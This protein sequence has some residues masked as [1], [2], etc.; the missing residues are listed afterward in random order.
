MPITADLTIRETAALSGVSLVT[1]EKTVEAQVMSPV[2][3]PSRV[4]G[5][6][7]RYLPLRAVVYFQ[8]LKAA[9]LT[10]LPLRHKR[11]IWARMAQLEPMKLETIEF[12]P[13]A[14]L[15]LERLA[16][17]SLREAERYRRDRDRYIASDPGILGGTPVIA[18][19]RVSV[20]SILGRLQDGD[21]VD[22]ILQDYPEIPREAIVAAEL[23]AKAHPL[24]GRPSGRPWRN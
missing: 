12:T 16:A 2:L 20:Y 4:R 19:T 17:D 7:M 10:D 3:G 5:G 9:R 23:Y 11:S 18:G 15:D 8:V 21:S 6:S 1:I 14:M 22:D 13:G 24:R